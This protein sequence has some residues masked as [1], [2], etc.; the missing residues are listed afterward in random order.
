MGKSESAVC[1]FDFMVVF[2]SFLI[3]FYNLKVIINKFK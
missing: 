2:F 3:V 1:P